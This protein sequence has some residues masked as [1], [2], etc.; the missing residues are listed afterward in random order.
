MPHSLTSHSP[1]T[2]STTTE[3]TTTES[4]T[5]GPRKNAD[6]MAVASFVSGLIGLL[7]FNVVL[8][9]CALALG[10]T[11]LA[12]RTNRRFRALLGCALGCA[13][14]VLL[15]VLAAAQ[16]TPSWHMGG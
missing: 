7:V 15:A 5:A 1:T 3:P 12:R 14:L 16:G 10:A 9:P 11:A 2:D 13:D 8:G 6:L 4:R